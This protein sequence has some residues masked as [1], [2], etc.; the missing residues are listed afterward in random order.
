LYAQKISIHEKQSIRA[1]RPISSKSCPRIDAIKRL[2]DKKMELQNKNHAVVLMLDA[3]QSLS[4]CYPSGNLKPYSIEWLRLQRGMMDPFINLVGHRPNSTTKTPNR[5][6]YYVYTYGIHPCAMSTLTIHLPSHSDHLGIIFDLD[7]E[8]FFSSSCSEMAKNPPQLLMSGNKQSTDEYIKYVND[9]IQMNKLT[10]R[11]Q[12][13]CDKILN[14]PT[15]WDTH[16]A[17]LIN[18]IDSQ[19]TEIMLMG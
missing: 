10:D 6:I 17:L 15:N 13:I 3:N 19:L 14:N 16:D 4:D 11:L 5:D 9:Q 2:N 18:K 7:I 8:T 12:T 1:N